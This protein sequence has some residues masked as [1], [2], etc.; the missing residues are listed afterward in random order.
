MREL[1][2][3][4][5]TGVLPQPAMIAPGDRGN[6]TIPVSGNR[7]EIAVSLHISSA[8]AKIRAWR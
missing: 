4:G 2:V 7:D 1:A 5:E 8:L 3:Q 6:R